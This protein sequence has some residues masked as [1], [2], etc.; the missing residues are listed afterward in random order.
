MCIAQCMMT[1]TYERAWSKG[2][3][4]SFVVTY[5]SIVILNFPEDFRRKSLG[6]GSPL[7]GAYPC[8]MLPLRNK[9]INVA[10]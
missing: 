1:T 7:G 5:K 10:S 6:V 3:E 9:Y 8:G 2:S 4:L